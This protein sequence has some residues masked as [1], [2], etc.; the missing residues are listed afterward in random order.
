M[1]LVGDTLGGTT[2]EVEEKDDN[3]LLTCRGAVVAALAGTE[4][5]LG[6]ALFLFA[7]G[8]GLGADIFWSLLS[9]WF[10]VVWRL[11][12]SAILAITIIWVRIENGSAFRKERSKIEMKGQEKEKKK[13]RRVRMKGNY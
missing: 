12:S 6:D 1:G 8:L 5:A 13:T 9:P 2:V 7:F 11:V 4:I 3:P 10:F